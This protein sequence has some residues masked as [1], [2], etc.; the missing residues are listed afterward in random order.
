MS[1]EE[2][3]IA[4]AV[5]PARQIL[6][7]QAEV[8]VSAGLTDLFRHIAPRLRSWRVVNCLVIRV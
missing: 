5:K 3:I 1:L 4:D 2:N 7:G 8:I 6:I